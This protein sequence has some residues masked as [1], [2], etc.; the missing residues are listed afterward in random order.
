MLATLV[1]INLV[2]VLALPVAAFSQAA[3]RRMNRAMADLWWGWCTSLGRII[4]GTHIIETGDVLPMRENVILLA[5]H[6]QMPDITFLM[7]LA[8]SR[9]RL[10]DM[11]WMLKKVIRYVPGIGWG[12]SFLDNVF[13]ARD[14]AADEHRIRQTFRN[15]VDHKVPCW[16]ISFPEGTRVNLAKLEASRDFQRSRSLAPFAHVLMPR[17]RGFVASVSGLRK[18]VDAIYDVTIGY[19]DGA[20]SLWQYVKGY[21]RVAHLH[22]RRYPIER[23]P[24]DDA[25]IATWLQERFREKDALL[26]EFYDAGQ[27]H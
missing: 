26:A 19:E 12:L 2:Q 27:F 17:S 5:N 20:P 15:L 16:L 18:H 25:E 24:A 7:F 1:L 4:Y 13:L 14:W 10:G 6:Q 11:K 21:V 9:G 8:Q 23:L 22:V 3:F